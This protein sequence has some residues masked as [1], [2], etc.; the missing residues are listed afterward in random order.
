MCKTPVTVEMKPEG[1]DK[2]GEPFAPVIWSGNC[3]YQ[4]KA[5]TVYTKEKEQIQLTGRVYIPGDIA[6]E[7]PTISG[8][9]VTVNG[10]KRQLYQGTKARNPDNTVNF[11]ML[12]V[13]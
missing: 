6:P 1:R 12:E 7:L 9:Y 10:E 8:G 5:K 2:N 11:T 4:D 13:V 3:N